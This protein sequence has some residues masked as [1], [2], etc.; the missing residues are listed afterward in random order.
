MQTTAGSIRAAALVG[1]GAVVLAGCTSSI[2]PIA[3][4][5]GV[6]NTPCGT[7]TIAVNPWVG[8][9]ANVAVVSYLAKQRL[10]CTVVEKEL[11]EADSWKGLAAG[12]V[13]AILE[14]WG[15]DD[16]RKKYIDQERVAVEHGVTG[17]K[18]VIGWYV[19]PWLA[20]KYPDI[21][22][23]RNLN[24]YAHLF[25]TQ[26]SGDTGQLLDGDPSYVT[27][28]EALVR[29]LKLD[30]KV[31]F[32]GSE[33]ALIAAFRAAEQ[34]KTPLLGYFYEPQWFLSE[35]ALVHITLPTYAPGCDAD[36]KTVACDYQ[37]YDLDK[38]VSRRFA[39]SGSPA[40]TLIK[41]FQWT[42][43]DQNAVARS[44]T[45]DKLTRD[46]AAKKW[47]D[48]HPEVWQAWLAQ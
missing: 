46:Q 18:G 27:N 11:T 23:W 17:N 7:V 19:P 10:G 31:V 28:D 16:L 43:A 42:N 40:A 25:R 36:P 30:F 45:V 39:G 1:V 2:Q 3:P 24:K 47:L 35:V 34:Q 33:D 38:I 21:V 8:Y 9:E 20:K 4:A 13:D 32:A 48:A 41:N 29:N 5:P 44:I 12:E 37:P 26:K 6:S 15:H 22:D 14:V